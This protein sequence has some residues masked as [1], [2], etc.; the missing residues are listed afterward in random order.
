MGNF[1]NRRLTLKI[2][3][4]TALPAMIEAENNFPRPRTTS[5]QRA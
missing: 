3:S 5:G 2:L 4:D 1:L